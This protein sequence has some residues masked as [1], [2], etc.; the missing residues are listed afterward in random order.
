[1]SYRQ[2]VLDFVGS[3]LVVGG[4]VSHQHE[5]GFALV[6][7]V[8]QV[9]DD[10]LVGALLDESEKV[11]ASLFRFDLEA[12]RMMKVLIV[13][14]SPHILKDHHPGLLGLVVAILDVGVVHLH[15]HI[16][17]ALDGVVEV[18]GQDEFVGVFQGKRV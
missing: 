15:V 8:L 11:F 1:M 6:H 2:F 16:D 10:E 5:V 13:D 7:I 3:P 12:Q 18:H 4:N 14:D 9:K 17:S